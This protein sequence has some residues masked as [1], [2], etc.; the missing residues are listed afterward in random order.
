MEV[1]KIYIGAKPVS[2]YV[3]A[4]LVMLKEKECVEIEARGR[5]I[6]KAILTAKGAER[7]VPCKIDSVKIDVDLHEQ[8]G[9]KRNVPRINILLARIAKSEGGKA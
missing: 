7:L 9:K 6:P 5:N 3:L 4:I 1:E 2:S 8:D